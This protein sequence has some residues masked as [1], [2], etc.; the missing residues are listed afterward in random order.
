MPQVNVIRWRDGQGW[1]VLS[2]GGDRTAEDASDIEAQ[3][4]TRIGLGE[5]VAYLWAA[6][7][8]E[9]ADQHLEVL[10]DLG[11]PTGYLVDVLTEDD[12]TISRQIAEAG[13]V[14]L[15]DGPNLEQLR[16]ATVGAALEGMNQA[17]ARGGVIVGIGAGAAL[18]G[19]FLEGAAGL[20][21]VE[22]AVIMPRHDDEGQAARL[23]SLLAAHPGAYGLGIGAGSALALG[24][25]GEVEAWGRRQIT[26]T[27]GHSSA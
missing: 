1:I 10:A 14:I 3:A 11:A 5:P 24:P 18:L 13:M 7:D 8:I 2:G 26:V 17:F 25:N 27:L 9:S 21:W 6:G 23:H 4:M 16:M 20:G 15:G 12:A 22:G 19:S